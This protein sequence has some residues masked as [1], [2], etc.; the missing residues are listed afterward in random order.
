MAEIQKTKDTIVIE[1][2]KQ[3]E[4]QNSFNL[5]Q[6]TFLKFKQEVVEN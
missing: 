1:N 5:A 3:K 2:K 6:K 4:L